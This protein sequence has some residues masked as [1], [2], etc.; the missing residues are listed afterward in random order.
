MSHDED[1][2][3][4]ADLTTLKLIRALIDI[5][6]YEPV[7]LGPVEDILADRVIIEGLQANKKLRV[8]VEESGR[9]LSTVKR[10]KE[11]YLAIKKK[12]PDK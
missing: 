6:G 2:I 5:Y 3:K 12:N 9:S 11:E 4:A 7:R 8:I 10:R 1:D